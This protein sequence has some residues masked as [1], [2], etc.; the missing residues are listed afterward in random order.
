MLFEV[1]DMRP[2]ETQDFRPQ[3]SRT[4][5]C[6]SALW[7]MRRN[8]QPRTKPRMVEGI[9]G[10]RAPAAALPMRYPRLLNAPVLVTI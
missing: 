8:S 10:L 5:G 4:A 2:G 7:A 1:G 9:T 3:P 6:S